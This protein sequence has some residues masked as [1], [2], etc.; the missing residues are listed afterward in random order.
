MS[1]WSCQRGQMAS[2]ALPDRWSADGR[3]CRRATGRAP[4][5][6]HVHG[7]CCRGL[8][9]VKTAGASALLSFAAQRLHAPRRKA[10]LVVMAGVPS[11]GVLSLS[12]Q[13][14]AEAALSHICIHWM[15]RSHPPHAS[16]CSAERRSSGGG[17]GLC[18]RYHP[19]T[20]SSLLPR[21]KSGATLSELLDDGFAAE[22]DGDF[23]FGALLHQV[24]GRRPSQD[25][26]P[27]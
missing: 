17:I 4:A 9:S 11:N 20:L 2:R 5:A 18:R 7:W 10:G 24:A 19:G 23:A 16:S 27:V 22:L 1:S 21:A 26:R 13:R 6:C 15:L 3:S 8:A 14:S 12:L 25:N